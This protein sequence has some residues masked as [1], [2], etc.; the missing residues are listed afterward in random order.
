MLGAVLYLGWLGY[1]RKKSIFHDNNLLNIVLSLAY[2]SILITNFFGFSVTTVNVLFY[3]I[4]VILIVLNSKVLKLELFEAP[5]INSF[6]QSVLIL[7]LI[8]SYVLFIRGIYNYWQADIAYSKGKT[9]IA[10]QNY[11]QGLKY[12]EEALNKKY[13]HVYHDE[14]SAALSHYSLLVGYEDEDS[15]EAT[16]EIIKL[17]EGY[18]AASLRA[19]P[20]NVLYWKTKGRNEYFYYY[21]TESVKFLEQGIKTLS[22]AEKI[23]PTDPKVLHSKALIYSLLA[24]EFVDK[25]G[26]KFS[27]YKKKSLESLEK[28][29]ELK[30]NYRDAYVLMGQLLV[31]YDDEE[32]ARRMFNFVLKN[33]EPNDTE[34]RKELEELNK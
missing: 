29:I 15:K 6:I 24:A 20:Q 18:N 23:A 31:Q 25:D 19:S 28:A 22:N 10:S 27:D 32:Q 4:P 26:K 14:I 5:K 7:V 34:V 16:D 33:I 17:S 30:K 3:L 2:L 1:D 9:F 12:L 21:A 13:E 11:D 8:I